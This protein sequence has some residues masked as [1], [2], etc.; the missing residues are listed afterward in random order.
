L[1]IAW[2]SIGTFA[3]CLPTLPSGL[4]KAYPGFFSGSIKLTSCSLILEEH[5]LRI[6]AKLNEGNSCRHKLRQYVVASARL[7]KKKKNK[8]KTI[9]NIH[10]KFIDAICRLDSIPL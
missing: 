1:A 6:C 8:K 5:C 7:Q 2:I 3:S 10:Q 4:Y 9:K